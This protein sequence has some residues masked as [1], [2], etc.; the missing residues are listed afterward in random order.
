MRGDNPPKDFRWEHLRGVA[1]GGD[2]WLTVDGELHGDAAAVADGVLHQAAVDVIVGHE[3]AGDGEDLLVG[4]EEQAGVVAQ[5]S[6]VLQPRVGGFGA[7]LMRTVEGEEL[8]ELQ[9]R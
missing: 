5:R 4:G 3:D 7:V 6:P 9:H 2:G 8:A 1:G